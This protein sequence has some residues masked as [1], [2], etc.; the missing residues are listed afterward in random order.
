MGFLRDVPFNCRWSLF[1]IWNTRELHRGVSS[2]STNTTATTYTNYY[3]YYTS[4]YNN[5]YIN[6]IYVIAIIQEYGVV[7]E[8]YG[9]VVMEGYLC[10]L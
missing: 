2:T 9:R 1:K 5:S 7:I 6:K 4:S 10:I 3:T 8:E